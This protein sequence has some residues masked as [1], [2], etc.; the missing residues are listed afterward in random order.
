MEASPSD[1]AT[2]LVAAASA[3]VAFMVGFNLG[4]FRVIFFDQLLTVWVIATIVFVAS[5]VSDLP[6]GTWG[7]RLVLL[8]P[9]LWLLSA[10][11]DNSADTTNSERIAFVL[12]LVVTVIAMPFV[13][14]ILVTAI[15]TDF[16]ELP[17][18]NKAA[19]IA[20]VGIFVI[21]GFGLGA[22]ND[23]LLNCD[24]FKISGNDLPENCVQVTPRG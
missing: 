1:R 18:K 7:R 11:I 10:W 14:W 12:T 15:N 19:V 16:V 21:I 20:A 6:P 24:D 13:A 9:S 8:L 5:I 17:S 22:R 23:L 4:A 3:V 2:L